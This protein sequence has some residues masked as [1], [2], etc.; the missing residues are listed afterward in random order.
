M[1]NTTARLITYENYTEISSRTFILPAVVA[2]NSCAILQQK[3]QQG[4]LHVY[5]F[6]I[7]RQKLIR[8]ISNLLKG[9]FTSHAVLTKNNCAM[10]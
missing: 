3:Y 6:K 9:K 7:E 10:L 1:H 8:Y 4:Q 2:I 5:H